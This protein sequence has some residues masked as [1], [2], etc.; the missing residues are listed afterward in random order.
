MAGYDEGWAVFDRYMDWV[1]VCRAFI[2]NKTRQKSTFCRKRNPSRA[3][4]VHQGTPICSI[5]KGRSWHVKKLFPAGWYSTFIKGHTQTI[6]SFAL[7][8]IQ[9]ENILIVQPT[10]QEL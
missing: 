5:E 7:Q 1:N 4:Y 6:T 8:G 2:K 10:V 3:H 9:G